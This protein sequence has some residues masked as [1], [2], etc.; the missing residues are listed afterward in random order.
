MAKLALTLLVGLVVSQHYIFLHLHS[1]HQS[2]DADQ[3]EYFDLNIGSM[4]E[5]HVDVSYGKHYCLVLEVVFLFQLHLVNTQNLLTLTI[6]LINDFL[7]S[8]VIA[9]VFPSLV[10]KKFLFDPKCFYVE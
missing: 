6:H 3:L 7:S 5:I 8:F 9:T 10:P 1:H 2:H 4:F